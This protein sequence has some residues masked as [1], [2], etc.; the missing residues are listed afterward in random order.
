MS[1]STRRCKAHAH[2]AT[3]TRNLGFGPGRC[4]APHAP[5]RPS[6]SAGASFSAAAV[7]PPTRR[8]SPH[9]PCGPRTRRAQPRT[10]VT[11]CSMIPPPPGP[12]SEIRAGVGNGSR[13]P[14]GASRSS[15]GPRG[16]PFSQ[17]RPDSESARA[18]GLPRVTEVSRGL[19]SAPSL[20]PPPS[21]SEISAR[22]FSAQRQVLKSLLYLES[23][24]ERGRSVH[25]P[26]RSGR[27][28]VAT[29]R[30]VPAY[31]GDVTTGGT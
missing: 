3:R 10:P 17:A 28:P 19:A 24:A 31:S 30:T 8:R 23:L 27:R 11:L 25:R 29:R 9:L 4:P 7:A 1:E 22:A 2:V 5:Q 15:V 18:A 14:A 20:P 12:G 13:A 26:S 21:V 16:Q 6:Q